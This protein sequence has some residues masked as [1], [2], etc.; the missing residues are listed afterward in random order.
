[1]EFTIEKA[2][3]P[4]FKDTVSLKTIEDL[5]AFRDRCGSDLVITGSDEEPAII[6]YD[7]YME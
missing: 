1:M 4:K 6:I 2:S 3:D 5:M 7:Y